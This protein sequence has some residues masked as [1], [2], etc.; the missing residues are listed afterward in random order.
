MKARFIQN[1]ILMFSV[2]NLITSVACASISLQLG[3]RQVCG[4]W[5]GERQH[6]WLSKSDRTL[7]EDEVWAKCI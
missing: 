6:K 7:T 1:L 2:L 3:N 4:G 5:A